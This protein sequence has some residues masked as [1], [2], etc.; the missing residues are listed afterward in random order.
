MAK[1][2]ELY[3][4]GI[5]LIQTAHNLEPLS[6]DNCADYKVYGSQITTGTEEE[7]QQ[8]IFVGKLLD[9]YE[10]SYVRQ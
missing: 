7:Q 8:A 2:L 5:N 4:D 6:V 10:N 9:I 1:L 3:A